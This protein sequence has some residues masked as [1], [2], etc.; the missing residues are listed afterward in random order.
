[1][2][3]LAACLRNEAIPLQHLMQSILK[4]PI[5]LELC[6]DN[7][8]TVISAT[9]GYSPSMRHL[10]RTQRISVGL[11]NEMINEEPRDG[12]G[13]ISIKKVETA[14]HKGDLF[15]KELDGQMFANALAMIRVTDQSV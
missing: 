10:P 3:S 11:I 8:A 14:K 2:V 15:T 7:A 9:K 6:E 5:D 13:R 4:K 12:E 1:M